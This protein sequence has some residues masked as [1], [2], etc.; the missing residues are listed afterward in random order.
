MKYM[1]W[2]PA[3]LGYRAALTRHV[4]AIID[5]MHEEAERD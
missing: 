1:S 3:D 5:L 2:G 4:D